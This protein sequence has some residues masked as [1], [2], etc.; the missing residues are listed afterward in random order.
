MIVFNTPY[1]ILRWS[2]YFALRFWRL[3]LKVSRVSAQSI[4][5]SQDYAHILFG[6]IF[7]INEKEITI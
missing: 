2:A 5:D 1:G 3:R 7:T 4:Q 6:S